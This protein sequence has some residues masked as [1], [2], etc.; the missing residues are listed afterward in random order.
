MSG[1]VD[2]H[3]LVLVHGANAGAWCWD[4]L[5]AELDDR[6]VR[7]VAVDLP[8]VGDDVD[9]AVNYHDD[10]AHV[11]AVVDSLNGPAVLCGNSYGGVVITEASAGDQRVRHLVYLAAFMLDADAELPTDLFP[12]TNPSLGEHLTVDDAGR[13][14]LDP[15]AFADL[16]VPQASA[17]VA[18]WASSR[19]KPMALLGAASRLN[20]VG[21]HDIAST[22][23]VCGEDPLLLPESQRLWASSRATHQV[24]VP[25]DHC[26]QISHPA[27]TAA[28]L[29]DVMNQANQ[30]AV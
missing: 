19:L 26:P 20:G 22:F 4:L 15:S 18:A 21:W 23:V 10:A 11:R 27:E 13:V 16:V 5:A 14:Q 30:G 24:E 7:W 1:A 28:I 8:S 25:F 2:E 29:A 9:P 3:T 6:G 12:H 17:D